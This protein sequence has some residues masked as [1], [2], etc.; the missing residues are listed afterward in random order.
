MRPL[1]LFLWILTTSTGSLATAAEGETQN[2]GKVHFPVSCSPEAQQQFDRAVAMLHSFWHPQAMKAFEEVAKTDSSCA[3]AYWGIAMAGRANP[4]VGPPDRAALQ[5]GLAAVAK[6]KV[7]GPKTQRERDYVAAMETYYQDWEKRDHQ[8]RVLAYENAMQQMYTRYP[9][10]S[11]AAVFYALAL[12]EAITVTPPDKKYTRQLKAAAI[13]EKVMA[14][15][16]EHPGALHYLIHSYDFPGLAERGL[17]AANRYGKVAPSAPHALHMPSHIYSVLGMWDESIKAN[18]AALE[19]AKGYAHAIDFMVYAYLQ[20]ARDQEVRALLERSAE[21]QKAQAAT[22]AANPT[23][24]VLAGYTAFA[25]IPARF[26]LERGEWA[27][28]ASLEPQPSTPVADAITYFAR[29][30]GAA[31]SG[32]IGTAGESMTQLQ[33]IKQKLLESKQDYWAD[34]VEIQITAVSAWVTYAQGKK[35]GALKLMRAAADREDASEKH[36][37][38]ENRLLPMRELLGDMLLARKK[39]AE[40]LREYEVSLQTARNR[41]RGLYGAAR[42]ARQL[43]DRKKAKDYYERLLSLCRY[44]GERPELAQAKRYLGR[45]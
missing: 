1:F 28:A 30:M 11:E 2:L 6:A 26:A 31:R 29:G 13:L 37:A 35:A 24:A 4:L 44:G 38:M 12:N 16:P 45:K 22:T 20:Q 25:A 32:E 39:P 23:G 8:T 15:Q 7:A 3:M 5:D 40:A 43:G 18:Q 42:A 10:D 9:E 27:K 21:L 41:Y 33:E 17:E 14:Q 19:A 36:V 34:Q